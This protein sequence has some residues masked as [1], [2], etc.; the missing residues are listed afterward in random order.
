VPSQRSARVKENKRIRNRSLRTAVKTAVTK[1]RRA[2][3][4]D[5][6]TVSSEATRIA[7]SFLDKTA[8]KGAI[9]RNNAA[10]RK[11]RLAKLL[12]RSELPASGN[13]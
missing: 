13:S 6:S 11:S 1:A 10:R 12:H 2:I 5:E 9:H 7:H 4:D 8:Q 3:R